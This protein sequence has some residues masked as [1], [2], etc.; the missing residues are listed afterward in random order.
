MGN[1]KN[2]FTSAGRK[3]PNLRRERLLSGCAADRGFTLIEV[4]AG[5]III[6]VLASMIIQATSGGLWESAQGVSDC[7]TFFELQDQLEEITRIY[8]QQL[9]TGNGAIDLDV[10]RNAI[11]AIPYVDSSNTGYLTESGG[12][13]TLTP[14]NTSLFLVTLSQGDQRIGSIFSR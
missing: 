8:Q 5:L 3:P 4:I 1:Q 13:F 14:S 7:R 9:T 2:Q 11:A 10:F 12:T 6:S